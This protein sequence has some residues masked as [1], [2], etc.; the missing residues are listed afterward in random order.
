MPTY[1]NNTDR[2]KIPT[3]QTIKLYPGVNQ[4]Y[5]YIGDLPTGVVFT[6]HTPTISPVVK[7]LDISSFPSVEVDISGYGK[8]WLYNSTDDVASMYFN[9]DTDN[10]FL[11]PVDDFWV[12]PT[13]Y[14]YGSLKVVSAGAGSIL[15]WGVVK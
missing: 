9:N 3:N 7:L 5:Q 6:S 4:V 8:I 14:R 2:V 13:D 10:A 12:L 15:A 11:L 1:T